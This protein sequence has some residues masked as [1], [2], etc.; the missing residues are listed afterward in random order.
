M[1]YFLYL[2]IEFLIVESMLC[3][4]SSS[5]SDDSSD[6]EGSGLGVAAFFFWGLLRGLSIVGFGGL[7]NRISHTGL[8]VKLQ[9]TFWACLR[10]G[11]SLTS[12]STFCASHS[13]SLI[14]RSLALLL[15]TW[16]SSESSSLVESDSWTDGS[17]LSDS[18]LW[19]LTHVACVYSILML[20][21]TTNL[22]CGVHW[23]R[24]DCWLTKGEG[25]GV[26][27]KRAV[28]KLKACVITLF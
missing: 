15:V 17:W 16:Y 28:L 23:M 2:A 18:W 14:A 22:P 12:I 10:F 19:S 9:L 25:W 3:A 6:E 21:L 20:E 26:S 13:M 5:H 7:A 1:S 24:V 11:A 8:L 27:C 4:W